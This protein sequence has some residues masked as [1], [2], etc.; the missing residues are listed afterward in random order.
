MKKSLL[1]LAIAGFAIAASVA[2]C[3]DSPTTARTPEVGGPRLNGG[4]YGSGGKTTPPPAD[5]TGT[6]TTNS[7]TTLCGG[8]YG[9][10]GKDCPPPPQ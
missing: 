4:L 5:S 9:S 8:L 6:T 7:F 2:G 3:T 1:R 10:G